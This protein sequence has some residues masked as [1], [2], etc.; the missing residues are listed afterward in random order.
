MQMQMI[1]S[2][3]GPDLTAAYGAL[4]IE[5]LHPWQAACLATPGVFPSRIDASK[6]VAQPPRNLLFSAPT[7]GGKSLV[8][9]LIAF[10]ALSL[11]LGASPAAAAATAAACDDSSFVLFVLPYVALVEEKAAALSRLLRLAPALKL[12]VAAIHGKKSA[13]DIGKA[14]VVVCTPEKA[15]SL[16]DRLTLAGSVSR[17]R[18]VVVDEIHFVGEPG[19]GALLEVFLAKIRVSAPHVQLVGMSATVPNMSELASWLSAA[20][21]ESLS[22]PVNL[23]EYVCVN[24]CV[25]CV[26]SSAESR[27]V[28]TQEP[29]A[30]LAAGPS[31]DA[32]ADAFSRF[33]ITA[34]LVE[35]GPGLDS[36]VALLTPLVAETAAL[37][38]QCLIF[39]PD[40]RSVQEIAHVL[41]QHLAARVSRLAQFA[42][43]E[44]ALTGSQR[45][46]EPGTLASL[47]ASSAKRAGGGASC[48]A[49]NTSGVIHAD[50]SHAVR[51]A[52]FLSSAERIR[53]LRLQ[54]ADQLKLMLD[55]STVLPT[56]RGKKR[57]VTIGL[58][59]A[60]KE[61]VTLVREGVGFHHAG[62]PSEV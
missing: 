46:W 6:G 13:F 21:F 51:D 42:E 53:R 41:R 49:V 35:R 10:S 62:L 15:S 2:W 20:C 57:T 3:A 37:G 9:E 47:E 45:H 54:A 38:G 25:R 50:S 23:T 56:S 12:K 19:R 4:G 8:A 59:A 52:S 33:A 55:S 43:K 5:S 30:A 17:I 7:S 39:A 34:T 44:S 11:D 27:K 28:V 48:G 61:M 16:L 29:T 32:A 1:K 60:V 14:R 18:C 40:R 26:S 58:H 24:G 22:R 31:A 36:R